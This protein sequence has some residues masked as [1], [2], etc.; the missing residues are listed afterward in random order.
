MSGQLW[1]VPAEGGYLWSANLSSKL[2]MSLRPMTKFRQFRQLHDANENRSSM[3]HSGEQFSWNVYKKL[4]RQGRRLT[5]TQTMPETGSEIVQHSL[6]VYEAGQGVPYTGKLEALAEHKIQGIIDQN[7]R[8]DAACYFDIEVFL[9]FKETPLRAAPTGGNSTTSVTVSENG[10]TGVTNNVALGTGHV[11]AIVD[12]MKERNI[13]PYFEDGSYACISNVS[14]Y[15]GLKNSLETLHQYTE[16]GISRIMYG[17]IGRYEDVRFIEQNQIPKGG[18]VD[19]TT[20]DPWEHTADEWDNGLSSWAMFFGAETVSEATV[21]SEQIR[22]KIPGDYGRSK[23]I[24]W[25][26]LGG[27]A[28]THPDADNARVVMWD[29]AA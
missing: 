20:Y 11:K 29:S 2:R 26:Y 28:L 24:A 3:M 9:Q 19:S 4:R 6:T 16:S 22:A 25:Y 8:Y 27:F 18:A 12:Y 15:R 21:L 17:E 7:L 14:T 1:Q 13:P 10:T 5:E 23:G